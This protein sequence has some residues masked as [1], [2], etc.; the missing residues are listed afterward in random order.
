MLNKSLQTLSAAVLAAVNAAATTIA[1]AATTA[2]TTTTTATAATT[3]TAATAVDSL[4]SGLVD[5]LPRELY[6]LHII[7]SN[8][9]PK[10]EIDFKVFTLKLY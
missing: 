5:S 2:A 10:K 7:N 1:G 3:T 9:K 8:S 4:L 6:G